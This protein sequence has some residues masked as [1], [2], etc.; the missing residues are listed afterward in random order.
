MENLLEGALENYL[1]QPPH[2][3]DGE[4]KIQTDKMALKVHTVSLFP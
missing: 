4:T 3:I 1:D 2:C